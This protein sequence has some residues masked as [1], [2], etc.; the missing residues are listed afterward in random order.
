MVLSVDVDVNDLALF[1]IHFPWTKPSCCPHCSQN[2][3]WHGF[4]LAYFSI[5][6]E[7][8][9]IRRFYCP[10]CKSTHRLRPSGYWP[11]FRSSIKEVQDSITHRDKKERWRPD[12]PRPRQRQWLLRLKKMYQGMLGFSFSGTMIQAFNTL[13]DQGIIPVSS[14]TQSKNRQA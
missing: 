5:L 14:A 12:L 3:W 2:I 10:H 4:V 6:A 7:P 9:Y 8:V 1:G 13:R 11:R